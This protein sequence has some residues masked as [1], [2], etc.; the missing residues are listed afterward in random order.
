MLSEVIKGEKLVGSIE[1][2]V[3]L[4]VAAFNFTV[5]S[6]SKGTN[7]LVANAQLSQGFLKQRGFL[8]P[9]GAKTIGKF[10]AVIGLNTLNGIGKTATLSFSL[11]IG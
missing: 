10:W 5:M 3:V 4:A 2:L 1:L 11:R 9:N 8:G 7:E 6:G